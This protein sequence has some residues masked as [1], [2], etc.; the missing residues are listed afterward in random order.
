MTE[1]EDGVHG[2]G[3]PETPQRQPS[4]ARELGVDERA[5]EGVVDGNLVAVEGSV[6]GHRLAYSTGVTEQGSRRS[7]PF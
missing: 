2:P 6:I 1:P 3:R 5:R 4:P 7:R